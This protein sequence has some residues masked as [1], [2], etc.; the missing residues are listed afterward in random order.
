MHFDVLT[1]GLCPSSLG[2][3]S[4]DCLIAKY[5]MVHVIIYVGNGA[6][7]NKYEKIITSRL[8]LRLE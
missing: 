2:R 7:A 6:G 8:H 3:A 1:S 4:E 5:G